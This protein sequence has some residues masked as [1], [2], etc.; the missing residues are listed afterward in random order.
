VHDAEI[1]LQKNEIRG[2]L[3]HVRRTVDRDPDIGSMQ[4]RGIVDAVA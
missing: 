3:R 4:R 2:R 1:M